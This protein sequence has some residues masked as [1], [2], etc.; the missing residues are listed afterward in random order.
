MADLSLRE[1][2]SKVR[3]FRDRRGWEQLHHPKDLAAALAIESAELQEL[4]LWVKEA[5]QESSMVEQLH[6][7]AGEL[8][9][10]TIYALNF[11]VRADI[12]LQ[13]VVEA[14]LIANETRYP[15]SEGRGE[16]RAD[17]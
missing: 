1:L 7:V 9:D 11:A 17:S 13:K 4:F 2:Q 10:I 16:A 14:K 15:A 8:A 3:E 12:D 5:D 6:E